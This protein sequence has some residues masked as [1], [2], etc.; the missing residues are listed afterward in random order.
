MDKQKGNIDTFILNFDTSLEEFIDKNIKN[1]DINSFGIIKEYS[2]RV[3]AGLFNFYNSLLSN[4]GDKPEYSKLIK[5]KLNFNSNKKIKLIGAH[6]R[7]YGTSEGRNSSII[8]DNDIYQQLGLQINC[9]L[10]FDELFLKVY[11]QLFLRAN[12]LNDLWIQS[13]KDSNTKTIKPLIIKYLWNDNEPSL[14]SKNNYFEVNKNLCDLL[15]NKNLYDKYVETINTQI[16]ETNNENIDIESLT[17]NSIK[18]L[19]I[20]NLLEKLNARQIVFVDEMQLEKNKEVKF[21]LVNLFF[22]DINDP[23]KIESCLYKISSALQAMLFYCYLTNTNYFYSFPY[24]SENNTASLTVMATDELSKECI[25]DIISKNSQIFKKIQRRTINL[26]K[27]LAEKLRKKIESISISETEINNGGAKKVNTYVETETNQIKRILTDIV[28]ATINRRDNFINILSD[29]C[30]LGNRLRNKK[31]EGEDLQFTF[32]L[33]PIETIGKEFKLIHSFG[34]EFIKELDLLN[35]FDKA[36]AIINGNFSFLQRD[37]VALFA[38]YP[39]G[40]LAFSHIVDIKTLGQHVMPSNDSRQNLL[41]N[42]TKDSPNVFIVATFKKGIAGLYHHGE[43]IAKIDKRES[44]WKKLNP[45]EDGFSKLKTEIANHVGNKEFKQEIDD[46]IAVINQISDISG[47]GANF[48]ICDFESF[49]KN[50][51]VRAMT[52][53]FDFVERKPLSKIGQERLFQ[54]ATQDGATIID[55]TTFKVSGRWQLSTINTEIEWSQG[56]TLMQFL[57]ERDLISSKF[58]EWGSRHLSGWACTLFDLNELSDSGFN[59]L[60]I[61]ISSDGP[62]VAFKEGDEKVKINN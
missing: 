27:E 35:Q 53:V 30:K 39:I 48:I 9:H 21:K 11:F 52:K 4:Y 23:I 56:K 7:G 32:L 2:R 42:A 62:I 16:S 40:E 57:E 1:P 31:H 58:Y 34:D 54:L 25:K 45:T 38:T 8:M 20:S 47:K 51:Y 12:T 37:D 22:N 17:Y 61:C 50:K 33:A 41:K 6:F 14:I 36:T 13:I 24:I 10:L 60:S 18:L 44:S 59:A 43:M 29:L 26:E 49:E 28:P 15:F 5:N 46:L 3:E 19:S 55:R